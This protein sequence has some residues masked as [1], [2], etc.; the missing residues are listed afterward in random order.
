RGAVAGRGVGHGRT[1]LWR[2]RP[3]EARGAGAQALDAVQRL[4]FLADPAA[5]L[6]AGV[7]RKEALHAELVVELVPDLLA[8]EVAHPRGEFARGHPVG[9]AGDERQAGVLVLPIV[10]RAVAPLRGAAAGR[11]DRL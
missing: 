11:V 10:G 1:N 3:A 7:T 5:G 6:R 9:H 4:D 2:D 8:A